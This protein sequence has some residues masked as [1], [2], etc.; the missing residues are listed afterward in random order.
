MHMADLHQILNNTCAVAEPLFNSTCPLLLYNQVPPGCQCFIPRESFS[1]CI[2]ALVYRA[3]TRVIGGD[4]KM[5]ADILKA[6]TS[7][8][9]DKEEQEKWCVCVKV[10]YEVAA[11]GSS[12]RKPKNLI[13]ESELRLWRRR[14]IM[15]GG[16]LS[17]EHTPNGIARYT[18]RI[19]LTVPIAG[20]GT[21]LHDPTHAT[22][23]ES[24]T[25]PAGDAVK[26]EA[27]DES[28]ERGSH[29]S[30]ID[31]RKR[32]EDNGAGSSGKG[33]SGGIASG[34]AKQQN[35]DKKT[36]EAPSQ[37]R[38]PV[39]FK[40]LYI[41]DERV[42]AYFF[43]KK[44]RRIFGDWCIVVHE[45]DGLAALERLT[46]G[47]AY[48]VIIS[49]IFM[50]GMDGISFFNTLFSINFE[51][52]KLRK[53]EATKGRKTFEKDLPFGMPLCLILTGADV[54]GNHGFD[55]LNEELEYL[56]TYYGVQVYNKTCTVDVITDVVK[57]HLNFLIAE[58]NTMTES[59]RTSIHSDQN[60]VRG[61]SPAG[62]QTSL[63]GRQIEAE[64]TEG[65]MTGEYAHLVL[66][67]GKSLGQGNNPFPET[68]SLRKGHKDEFA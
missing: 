67:S 52:G 6:E 53:E 3:G 15:V 26:D 14:L 13:E 19:I 4:C 59:E 60:S 21:F 31:S 63:P 16:S 22:R 50:V 56:T 41:E 28:Q 39:K 33:S 5:T 64:D 7:A 58:L 25:L 27:I 32:T 12:L 38:S 2:F 62:R 10:E 40:M 1:C 30:N 57:P 9:K 46:R 17:C 61:R 44:C 68:S 54:K 43:I 49:D 48:D 23:A 47:E 36:I 55:A 45:T 11:T 20:S 35:D 66:R 18:E 24:D 37:F 51:T 34:A 42:Q 65:P 8:S 29:D